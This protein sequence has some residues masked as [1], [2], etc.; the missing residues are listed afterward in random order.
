MKEHGLF[1][2]GQSRPARSGKT[3]PSLNP[4][5]GEPWCLAAAA[6]VEDLEDAISAAKAAHRDGR[7]R[8]KS[9]DERAEI[10]TRAGSILFDRAEEL[11]QAEIQDSG[12]TMRQAQIAL[13][14][15]AGGAFVHYAEQLLARP[16][17][18]VFEESAPVN[19]RNI[20]RKEP[21]GVVAGI[22]PFNFSLAA[23]CWKIAPALAA[24]NTIVLKPSPHT[25]V[26]A[27]MVAEACREAGVPDGVVNVVTGPANELGAA[28]TEHPDVALIHFTGSAAVGKRIIA[29]SSGTLK[30]VVL[31]LGGKSPFIVLD[32]ANLESAVRGALFANYFNNGQA[33]MGGTRVLVHRTIH[34]AFVERMV[35]IGRR[36]KVG[37]AMDYETNIGPL[38]SAAQVQNVERYVAIGKDEGARCVLGGD[39]P[40]RPGFFVNPTIFDGVRNDMKI[41]RDEIFGPVV[42]VIPF[43]TDEEAL[44]IANDTVYGLAGAVWTRDMDRGRR[45]AHRIE[46]GTV[47]I[48]DYHLLNLR[49]PFGGYKQ[50]GIGREMGPWGLDEFLQIKHVHEGEPTGPE[51]KSYFGILLED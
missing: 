13:L 5:T 25:P 1:I 50:S 10:L 11:I 24:G 9:R 44:A 15:T 4:S 21:Y 48:N 14:P 37:D 19:S 6:G 46:A 12:W 42:S 3:A 28:L 39:R 23:A 47:W 32:D 51:E 29:A 31:E 20:V 35:D 41:A 49:F 45:F 8:D 43:D 18:E 33:C 17:E 16:E 34:G 22:T 40:D 26:T 2:D 30:K 27:G 38:I 36:L 7:W